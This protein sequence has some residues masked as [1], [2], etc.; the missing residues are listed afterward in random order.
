MLNF[1]EVN[2]GFLDDIITDDL[3]SGNYSEII[4]RFPPEPNGYLHI[5][6]AKAISVNFG[7]AEKYGGKCNLRFDDTNPLKEDLEYVEAIKNDIRWLGFKVDGNIFYASEYFGKM[8]EFALN[9]ISAGLAYVCQLSPEEMREY[10]GTLTSP[11]KNSPFRDRTI[12]DNLKLF[13]EMKDGLHDEGSMVLRL[14]IDMASPNLN[15]RD[16]IIYRILKKNHHHVGEGWNIYPMY[17]YA[18]PIEDA[19]ENITNSFCSLEFEDHRPL[20]DFIIEKLEFKQ[21]P[22]QREFARLNINYTVMSKRKLLALVEEGLVDGWDDPRMPTISGLRRRGYPKDA[23]IKFVIEAGIAKSNSVVDISQLEAAV[24]EELNFTA[25]RGMAVVEPLKVIVTNFENDVDWLEVDVNPEQIE[26]GKRKIPFT[27]ELYI[28]KSDFS[29]NPQKGYRRLF[30]GNEVRFKGAYYLKCEDYKVDDNG[31][32]I[33]VYCTYDGT[34]KGGWSTD[35]RKVKGT[36][37]WISVEHALP[38][39]FR[40]FDR[41]FVDANP[42]KGDFRENINPKS[43]V[44]S[45]GYVESFLKDTSVDNACQFLRNGYFALDKDSTDERLIFNRVVS[46]K[47]SFNK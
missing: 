24:R 9:L 38:C 4:T 42:E 8:Y 11:G 46:L 14:K 27:K 32:V 29:L 34:T 17:D 7:L 1:K 13:K 41:L 30:K 44:V 31:E 18:H 39:E 16:P 40:L 36:I 25:V 10:R 37:H 20:Y 3:N 12:E 28:E 19:L 33:E 21:K 23:I 26:L 35:G 15:M 2:F 22:K 45:Q 6:H 5:G 47:D 43:K